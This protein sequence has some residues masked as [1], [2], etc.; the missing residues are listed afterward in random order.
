LI[1]LIP[2]FWTVMYGGVCVKDW[3]SLLFV[4]NTNTCSQLSLKLIQT[5]EKEKKKK[6]KKMEN[7]TLS[8]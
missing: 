8:L 2:N 1:L 3:L 6:E 5:T 4:I 7:Y